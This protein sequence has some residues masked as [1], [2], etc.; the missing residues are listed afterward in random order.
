M[1]NRQKTVVPASEITAE[2]RAYLWQNT[3][4]D[5]RGYIRTE[6]PIAYTEMVESFRGHPL[7]E[8]TTSRVD[9]DP[10]GDFKISLSGMLKEDR[11][12][13]TYIFKWGIKQIAL[14]AFRYR[15]AGVRPVVAEEFLQ[16]KVGDARATLA[17]AVAK[18][19]G[20]GIWKMGWMNEGID[21][22]LWV[23][24][25][26]T[27]S[28]EPKIRTETVIKLGEVLAGVMNEKLKP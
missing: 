8:A 21:Y 26:L 18:G 17:L 11:Y 16:Q 22:E 6:S 14:T 10:V 15:D 3:E 13:T 25:D 9:A 2:E 1:L 4:V 28:D 5:R 20:R 24:D 23:P 19:T 27:P 7:F 12:R